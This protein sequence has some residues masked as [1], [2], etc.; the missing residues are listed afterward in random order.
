M[1]SKPLPSRRLNRAGG[2]L[3]FV[4][5]DRAAELPLFEQI[6]QSIRTYVI[7][8]RLPPGS[9]LASTRVL[10]LEL[11]VSRFTVVNA[12]DR[13]L[14]EGYL[15]ARRGAGTF[16]VET[17]PEQRMSA[18]RHSGKPPRRLTEPVTSPAL[19]SRGTALSAVVITGPRRERGEPRPFRPRRPPLDVFPLRL[20]ARLVRRQ[21]NTSRLQHLDYGEPAGYRP[22]REAI[23]QHVGA[24]RGLRCTPD[25]IV[26]TSGAQQAFDILFRLLLDSGDPAWIEEPGY[27]DVRAALTAAGAEIVPVPVD[28]QGINVAAGVERAPRAR[29]AVV[30]PSH[31]YPTGATLSATRRAQLLAWARRAGAWIVEDDYDCYFRYRGRPMSA[32]QTLDSEASTALGIDPR[33]LYVSTF[34]K[35]MFPSLR[36]GFCVVPVSLVESVANARAVADRNSPIADQAALAEFIGDGHFDRHL[37]R[38]RIVCQERHE[39]MR[40]HFQRVLGDSVALEPAEAGT[41]VLCRLGSGSNSRLRDAR[42]VQAVAAAAADDDLVVFP[43]SRYCLSMPDRDALVLGYGGLTPGKIASGVQ[44]LARCIDRARAGR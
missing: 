39:A 15:V 28:A 3:P 44:R 8:G 18:A 19:S 23:A 7:D 10:A 32:L 43:L 12:L 25:Q 17:L 27:L 30:S 11:S 2:G 40:H 9:R 14:A 41:H 5:L 26:V 20:W 36:L 38:V 42:F 4:S 21:W 1:A 37:R 29:L 35:T 6:Y 31:Q 24:T 22:L 34:S 13:L 33:V 16:V